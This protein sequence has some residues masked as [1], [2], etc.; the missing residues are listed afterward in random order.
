MA[1]YA[2]PGFPGMLMEQSV[3]GCD[4]R[5]RLLTGITTDPLTAAGKDACATIAADEMGAYTAPYITIDVE[6][7]ETGVTITGPPTISFLDAVDTPL[8][9]IVF[10]V[11]VDGGP[12]GPYA[13]V[14]LTVDSN[15]DPVAPGARTPNPTTGIMFTGADQGI[16]R[17]NP[18]AV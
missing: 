18:P 1:S 13:L 17:V 12:S 14:D 4:V 9:A 7:D 10:V 6:W 15:G 11:E 8:V 2:T 3:G 5:A 16:F